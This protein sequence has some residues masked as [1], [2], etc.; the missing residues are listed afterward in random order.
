[1][2]VAS[3]QGSRM[4]DDDFSC[5]TAVETLLEIEKRHDE[6]S[7]TPEWLQDRFLTQLQKLSP[8]DFEHSELVPIL[9]KLITSNA[10]NVNEVDVNIELLRLLHAFAKSSPL[11]L[12]S[13]RQQHFVGL[14]LSFKS[15]PILDSVCSTGACVFK[16][17]GF[18]L[19]E[20]ALHHSTSRDASW[21][22]ESSESQFETLLQ[23]PS[24]LFCYEENIAEQF[25]L[26]LHDITHDT[27]PHDSQ[28]LF[29]KKVSKCLTV[30]ENGSYADYL[31][32]LTEPIGELYSGGAVT[33]A[34]DL[35][36]LFANRRKPSRSARL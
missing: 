30:L 29:Q 26:L 19:L 31:Q 4:L 8:T 10:L 6:K 7:E 12:F 21:I 16:A 11:T 35:L 23:H 5:Q 25:S 9:L 36:K 32:H 24:L 13:T 34:K 20:H 27:L 3:A 22:L 1:M 15:S 14:V 33:S 2:L 17:R 28:Q 18:E